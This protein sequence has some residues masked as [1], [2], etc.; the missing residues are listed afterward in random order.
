MC[1]E[2]SSNGEN[3]HTTSSSDSAHIVEI[4]RHV[5]THIKSTSLGLLVWMRGKNSEIKNL[6]GSKMADLKK[7]L[8]VFTMNEI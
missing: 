1:F 7:P 6:I 3:K 8:T 5:H 2:K 4:S